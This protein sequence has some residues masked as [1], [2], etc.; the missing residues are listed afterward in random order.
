MADSGPPKPGRARLHVGVREE[1]AEQH[2]RAR[3]HELH[4]GDARQLLRG[5]LHERR[6]DRHR[7][8]RAHQQERRHDGDLAAL[9]E[10]LHHL[11]HRHV[12][13]QRRVDVGD[14]VHGRRPLAAPPR[15]RRRSPSSRASRASCRRRTAPPCRT[16]SVSVSC[17]YAMSRCRESC[18]RSVGSHG[19][20]PVVSISSNVCP[21][22][23]NRSRSAIVPSRRSAPSST[24]GAPATPPNTMWSPPN[25]MSRAGLR[26]WT[27][28]SPG[29]FATCSSRKSGSNRTT[30]SSRDV[31][32]GRA[33]P[34]LRLRQ[35][36]P[37]P[38]LRHQPAP[39]ALERRHRLGGQDV[40]AG[41]AVDEHRCIMR[42][43][44]AQCQRDSGR[45]PRAA[46][47]RAGRSGARRPSPAPSW[48][49]P[50]ASTAR[51]PGACWR[52]S[53]RTISS[54]ATPTRA[55]TASGRRDAPGGAHPAAPPSRA[56]RGRSSSASRGTR[57]RRPRS[58][59]GA[60][61]RCS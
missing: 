4:V 44:V 20:S 18:G 14:A 50:P 16:L 12:V 41:H 39:A 60:P 48:R 1:R 25:T 40:V 7:R 9:G 58:R 28:N 23:T 55:A 36:E 52:R 6:R 21:S 15:R 22:C 3:P 33:E 49:P 35:V 43:H 54:S 51:P 24:N 45:R 38:D 19:I 13:A 34:L 17:A 30:P 8:H 11:E 5:L 27:A 56:A 53:R 46:P 32:A 42:T 57:A 59:S 26:A 29:A 31:L 10:R 37:D 61:R 47:A 2:R